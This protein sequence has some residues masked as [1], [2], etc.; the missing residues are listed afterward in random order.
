LQQLGAYFD[1]SPFRARF[2]DKGRF[3]RYVSAIPHLRDHSRAVHLTGASAILDS[4]L[5]ALHAAPGSAS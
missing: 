2:E 5:R 1:R 4:Q 3:S